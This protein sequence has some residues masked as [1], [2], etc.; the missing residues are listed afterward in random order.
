MLFKRSKKREVPGDALGIFLFDEVSSAIR[1]EKVL[2]AEECEVA[3]VAPPHHLRAGCDLAVSVARVE[4]V[5]AARVL[6]DA[7]V[8]VRE[9]VDDAEGTAE[10]CDLV[11]TEDF[12]EWLMIRSGNMKI[13]V[14]RENG[15]IVNTS[16]GGCPD[17][18][19]LNIELVGKTIW[20]APRPKELGY[21]LC[22]LMLDRAFCEARELLGGESR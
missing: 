14:R 11:T 10:V 12:G 16:G 22:G 19:Y 8:V 13:T 9:W 3:L 6:A 17:I 21:T 20:E 18:P 4:Y 1:A 15:V 5:G 7:G 2:M